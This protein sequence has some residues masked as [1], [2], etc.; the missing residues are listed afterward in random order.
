MPRRPRQWRSLGKHAPEARAK[1]AIPIDDTTAEAIAEQQ[2]LFRE[3]FGREPEPNDPLFFDP[4]SAVP[5]FLSVESQEETWR[6]LVQAAGG[7][8]M[9]P[10]LVYAMNK[11]GRIVTDQ[12]MRFLKT[13]KLHWQQAFVPPKLLIAPPPFPLQ[14]VLTARGVYHPSLTTTHR[15]NGRRLPHRKCSLESDT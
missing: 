14:R 9:D 15:W 7:S 2:R 8:G 6:A 10:A 3:K 5:E 1:E 11:T 4:E 13:L 12:N